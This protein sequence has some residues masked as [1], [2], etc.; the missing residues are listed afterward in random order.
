MLLVSGP[1]WSALIESED[2]GSACRVT[3]IAAEAARCGDIVSE[4]LERAPAPESSDDSL[5][6]VNFRCA[7]GGS[8]TLSMCRDVACPT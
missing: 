2:L 4:L 8:N 1:G 5:R 7:T 6:L 3:V